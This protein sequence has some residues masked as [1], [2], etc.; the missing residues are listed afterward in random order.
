[1]TETKQDLFHAVG[2][3][4]D[5]KTTGMHAIAISTVSAGAVSVNEVLSNIAMAVGIVASIC[6]IT[7]QVLTAIQKW[8]E[9]RKDKKKM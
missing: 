1:V 3:A 9:L 4:L 2:A 6:V 7:V 5:A 8:R